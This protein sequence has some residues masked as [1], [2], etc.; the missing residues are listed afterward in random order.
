MNH[1]AGRIRSAAKVLFE[2]GSRHMST[3]A[4]ASDHR[5]G[6]GISETGSHRRSKFAPGS[7]RRVMSRLHGLLAHERMRR[8]H[9]WRASADLESTRCCRV[10]S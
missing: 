9:M 6:R 2:T 10:E 8:R 5:I 1:V 3:G 4:P 7:R